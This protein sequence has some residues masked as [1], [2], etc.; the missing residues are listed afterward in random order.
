MYKYKLVTETIGNQ[1]FFMFGMSLINSI[2]E[3]NDK[4]TYL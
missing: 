2:S 3:Y 4:K 1:L